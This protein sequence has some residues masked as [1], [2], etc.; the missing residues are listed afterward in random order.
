LS[1]VTVPAIRERMVSSLRNVSEGLAAAVAKGLGIEL[2]V[3]MPRALERVP[4]AEVKASPA[5][6]LTALPGDGGIA[7][8]RV[9]ILIADG[10]ESDSIATLLGELTAAGA[11]PR[12]LSMRL[13]VVRS[14]GGG[15]FEVD[16]TLENS[17]AVLFDALVLPD[18]EKAVQ[19]LAT[20]GRALEF[21][22]DTYRHCKT[23]L[24]LGM[25]SMLLEKIGVAEV[26]P[27]G[28]YDPGV[29]VAAAGEYEADVA[30]FM[31]AMTRHRHPERD[32][33]PP[34]I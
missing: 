6:S 28:Q 27:N 29:L 33:D 2:P 4:K 18:G 34:L 14:I 7:T 21:I 12:L 9:A 13:G 26:L 31:A 10:M 30:V 19:A 3:A 25:S 17:P 24:A 5:L 20:D 32:R 23:I 15:D 22:K 16:A 8:R 11:V 1:K